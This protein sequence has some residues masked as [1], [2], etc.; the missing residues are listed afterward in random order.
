MVEGFADKAF[1]EHLKSI[2]NTRGCGVRVKI[3]NAK[4]KGS[5]S[6]V[7]QV[8]NEQAAYDS[9]AAFFDSDIPLTQTLRKRSNQKK[10]SC[11]QSTPCLEGFLLAILGRRVPRTSKEC[12]TEFAAILDGADPYKKESYGMF[13]KPLLEAQRSSLRELDLLL[14]LLEGK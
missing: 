10:I 6:V 8:I 11:I 12:K 3:K 9:R 14:K 2:Y 13:D 5:N 4:G 7:R 1:V